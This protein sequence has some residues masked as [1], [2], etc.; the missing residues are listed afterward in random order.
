MFLFSSI[1][2]KINSKK[3]KSRQDFITDY[4]L[5]YSNSVAYNG[6]NN[7]YTNTAQKLLEMCKHLCYQSEHSEQMHNLE[8]QIALAIEDPSMGGDESMSNTP[9]NR[10][11]NPSRFSVDGGIGE[12]EIGPTCSRY[13]DSDPVEQMR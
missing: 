10:S 3:Y 4:E 1:F 9:S 8:E 5:L 6:L 2:Q 12:T 11:R 7:S 13:I